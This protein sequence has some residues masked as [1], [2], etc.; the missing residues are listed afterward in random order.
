MLASV[1]VEKPGGNS[2]EH[3]HVSHYSSAA[4]RYSIGLWLVSALVPYLHVAR[5]LCSRGGG[6]GE[7]LLCLNDVQ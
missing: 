1:L 3:G 4:Y 5:D 7:V 6:C 2:A